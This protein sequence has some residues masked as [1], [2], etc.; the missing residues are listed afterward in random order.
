[1]SNPIDRLNATLG[2]QYRFESELGRGGMATVYRAEDLRHARPVAVK[3]LRP[4]QKGGYEPE[5]FLR[6][7]RIAARLTHPQI[8]PVHDSGERDGVLYYVMP[9]IGGESLRDRLSRETRLPVDQALRIARAVAQALDYAHRQGILHRDIKPENILLHEGEALVADFGVARAISE[10][11]ADIVTEPGLAIGTPAYM[12]PEQASGDRETDGRSDQYSLACVLHEMLAGQPPFAGTA[13][14]A[15]MARQAVEPAPPIRQ[16]RA[17]VPVAVEH[18]LLRALSKEPSGR[19]PTAAEFAEALVTPLSGLSGTFPAVGRARSIAVLP[20]VNASADQENEYFSDG[21]TDEL[22][23]ALAN[24][25]G[26]VVASRTSAFALKGRREDVRTIG[27][28]L[29]VSS[30]LEGTVRKAGS[31]LRITAQLINVSDGRLLWSERFDREDTDV[32]AIQDE[33]ART[34]VNTLRTSFLGEMG[35]PVP[36]RYTQNLKAYNFYLRGRFCWNKRTPE[37]ISEAIEYFEQAIAEDPE[38]ALAY[39]GLAD[40]YALQLD[41]RAAPVDEGMRRAKQEALHAIA[42]DDTLAEAHTSLAWVSFIHDWEWEKARHHFERSISL[43]P[44]YATGRQWYAWYLAAMGRTSEALVQGRMA[45]DLDPA[46]VSIRR[47]MGWLHYYSHEPE[48]AIEH[49]ER[50]LM[51]NPT[52]FETHIIT[53]LSLCMAGRYPDAEAAFREALVLQPQDTHAL[54]ALARVAILQGRQEEARATLDEFHRMTTYRYVSPT[55]FSKLLIAL[56]EID[57]AFQYA[58]R[59]MLERRG[60]L[61]YMRVEPLFDGLRLHPK[62]RE[63][64]ARMGLS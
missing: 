38:Y 26:L 22:I 42:L 23:N 40:S 36:R 25:E 60:W 18:A 50:A 12:S 41:Y 51:M 44:R 10:A 49:L 11:S 35:E 30:V 61:A 64:L 37:G 53:G 14:R 5:R 63:L 16:L 7:V 19:F 27:A 4:G 20:F 29:N 31:R 62:Y 34:I 39:T 24:V 15:T 33:I 56:G 47:A 43:N 17:E 28:M 48:L 8:V 52:S 59:S 54:A 45:I 2:T 21:M 9:L 13:P 57:E 46:S 1:V 58:E 32:F 55:D 3:V 6:E